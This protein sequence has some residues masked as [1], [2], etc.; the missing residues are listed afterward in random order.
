MVRV[1]MVVGFFAYGVS[2]VFFV[3]GLRHLGTVRTAA[4]FSVAPFIGT[5]LALVMGEPIT[6]HCWS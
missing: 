1:A 5:I 3:I 2:L 6:F 4:Y